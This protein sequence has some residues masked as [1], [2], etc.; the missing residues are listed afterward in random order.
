[1]TE[2]PMRLRSLVTLVLVAG[3]VLVFAS[4]SE[5]APPFHFKDTNSE[6]VPQFTTC[7]GHCAAL[8]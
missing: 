4:N 1:M 6:F 2:V 7:D 3:C 5:A 8:T